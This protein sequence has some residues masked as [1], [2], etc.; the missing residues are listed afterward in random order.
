ME[1]SQFR[2]LDI[3]R[4]NISEYYEVEYWSRQFG[5]QPL[6]FKE[7]VTKTGITS[8]KELKK[9]LAKQYGENAA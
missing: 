4:I 7:L 3:D 5:L 2:S 8:A 9:Y 1:E 6:V